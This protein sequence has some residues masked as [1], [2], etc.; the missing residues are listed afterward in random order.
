MLQPDLLATHKTRTRYQR[1]APFYDLMEIFS[2]KRYLPWR[3]RLWSIV[4]GPD[5]LEVGIGT[6]KNIPLYPEGANIE[7][8][9][10]AQ[11]M[12][13]RAIKRAAELSANVNIR[14]GDVQKLDF[15]D[16][17][18]DTAVATFVF[19]SV[20]DPVM[21][22]KELRRVIKPGGQVFLLEHV[23]STN[24]FLGPL[25][26]ILNPFIVRITGANINRTT[27]EKVSKAGF[28]IEKDEK[29]GSGDIFRFIIVRP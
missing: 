2:E 7:A 4:E 12:V 27:V 19:C 14:T 25:M 15:P 21:G 28:N 16:A 1:I 13:R 6:G 26:D 8:I 11:G 23:R 24:V 5:I 3:Q 17:S 18:F 22:L 10:L 29:L 20:P 9:D